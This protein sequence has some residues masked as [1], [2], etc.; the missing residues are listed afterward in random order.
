[1]GEF[2]KHYPLSTI[3]YPLF[4]ILSIPTPSIKSPLDSTVYRLY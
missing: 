1:M 3:H 4:L 2:K